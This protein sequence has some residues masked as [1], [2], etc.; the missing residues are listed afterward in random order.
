MFAIFSRAGFSKSLFSDLENQCTVYHKVHDWNAN[1]SEIRT[2]MSSL[3]GL[4]L[5]VKKWLQ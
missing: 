3:K 4:S 2:G 1:S 5:N